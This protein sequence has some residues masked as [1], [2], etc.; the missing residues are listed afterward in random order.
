MLKP[1]H[2]SPFNNHIP[3][4]PL[5]ATFINN[6]PIITPLTILGIR[7]N[8][9]SANSNLQVLVQWQGLS[10][11][12]TSWEDWDQLRAVYNLEENVLLEGKMDDNNQKIQA[13]SGAGPKR[14]IITPTYLK[15]FV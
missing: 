1:F 4:L 5:P 10:S 6:Q 12:D 14:R 8:F 9:D 2:H 15:D 3:P 7:R 13:P 11:D